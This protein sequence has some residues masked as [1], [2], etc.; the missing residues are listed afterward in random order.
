MTV[1]NADPNVDPKTDD[2]NQKKP[3]DV[4]TA[5]TSEEDIAKLIAEAVEK[6]RADEKAKVYSQLEE[7]KAAKLAAEAAAKEAADQAKVAKEAQEALGKKLAEINA[8]SLDEKAKA[9]AVSA[10]MAEQIKVLQ[11]DIQKVSEHAANSIRLSNLAAFRE[12]EIAASGLKHLAATVVGDTEKEVKASLD[13]ALTLEKQIYADAQQ[14]VRKDTK[15]LVQGPASPAV[16]PSGS[17]AGALFEGMTAREAAQ[18]P[19]K[20]FREYRARKVKVLGL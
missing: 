6:A 14:A 13:K 11:E 15:E 17:A 16:G 3:E 12:R 4:T 20:E 19:P 18:L 10:A 5:V 8:S 1:P 2:P 9:E 7:Q